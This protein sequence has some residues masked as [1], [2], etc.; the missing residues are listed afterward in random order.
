MS[1]ASSYAIVRGKRN[2][3]CRWQSMII[4]PECAEDAE[5]S[6]MNIQWGNSIFS[7]VKP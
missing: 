5:R 7:S 3:G 6:I 1:L 4:A 2:S